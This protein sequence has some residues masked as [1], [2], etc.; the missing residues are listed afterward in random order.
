MTRP[1]QVTPEQADRS[2]SWVEALSQG[3]AVLRAFD[4]Q[5]G[6]LTLTEIAQKLGW[7]RTKPYRYI[8]TLE[9]LGYLERQEGSKRYRPTS[10]TMALGYSYLSGL[11]LLELAQPVLERLK[12]ELGASV[13]MGILERGEVVYIA[14]A[15]VSVVPAVDIYVGS[16]VAPHVTSLGRALMSAMDDEQVD[17]LIGTG[18][19]PASTARSITDP[20][21]FRQML[22]QSRER[23]YVFTD[24]EFHPGVRSIAA[25]IRDRRGEVVAAINAT[26]IVQKFSDAWLAEQVIPRVM[27]A[28]SEI[29]RS[30]GFR[31]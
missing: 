14:S 4:G 18:E 24:E 31:S 19:L 21:A 13:H 3:L 27:A 10:L 15:R 25:P 30:M 22:R 6:G 1:S 16:R 23:G 28:A 26:S 17:A 12:N 11:S 8:Y 7:S 29:S 5:H 20:Q 9:Q 2:A